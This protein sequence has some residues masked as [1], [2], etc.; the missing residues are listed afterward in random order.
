MSNLESINKHNR[1][2]HVYES[3]WNKKKHRLIFPQHFSWVLNLPFSKIAKRTSH[4]L[5]FVYKNVRSILVSFFIP[6]YSHSNSSLR[7]AFGT[8]WLQFGKSYTCYFFFFFPWHGLN[9]T[10]F[11]TLQYAEE[12]SSKCWNIHVCDPL[13]SFP[14][15][16]GFCKNKTKRSYISIS[17][18]G[19]FQNKLYKYSI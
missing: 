3:D 13:Q 6:L 15:L 9:S 2:E 17:S 5:L 19:D 11:Y 16:S 12:E 10:L 1:Y 7:K 4:F 8:D 14:L 18:I